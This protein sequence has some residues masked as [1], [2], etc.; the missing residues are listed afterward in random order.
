MEPISDGLGIH[1]DEFCGNS[2]GSKKIA[3]GHYESPISVKALFKP[4]DVV[5]PKS[6]H[7]V[8]WKYL[9]YSCFVVAT[10]FQD[11]SGDDYPIVI[12]EQMLDGPPINPTQY[13]AVFAHN[14]W[15][16]QHE[17]ELSTSQQLANEAKDV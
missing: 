12:T 8:P 16:W 5:V 4:G 13:G 1:I 17:L 15:F 7:V 3:K 11:V 9:K 10:I 6:Y 14:C 2:A